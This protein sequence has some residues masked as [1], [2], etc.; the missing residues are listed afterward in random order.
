M[1]KYGAIWPPSSGSLQRT[2]NRLVLFCYEP[3]RT[4]RYTQQ[5]VDPWTNGVPLDAQGL[6]CLT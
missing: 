6:R 4:P 2:T 3:Q 1:A 5:F